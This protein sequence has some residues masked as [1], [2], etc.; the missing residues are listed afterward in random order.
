[1]LLAFGSC[2]G[3]KPWRE[4]RE[5]DRFER[6]ADIEGRQKRGMWADE[7]RVSS[8]V[9]GGGKAAIGGECTGVGNGE[10][11]REPWSVRQAQGQERDRLSGVDRRALRWVVGK[12]RR[13]EAKERGCTRD[14]PH[15]RSRQAGRRGVRGARQESK[16][17]E[18]KKGSRIFL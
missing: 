8:R 7:G 9:G 18:R 16:G 11:W 10:K 14:T 3:W 1:M 12:S 13:G 17:M 6:F 4:R 5:E 15:S 2:S